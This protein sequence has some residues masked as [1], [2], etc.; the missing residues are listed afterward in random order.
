[1]VDLAIYSDNSQFGVKDLVESCIFLEQLKSVKIFLHMSM[2]NSI[3][4]TV[5][6]YSSGVI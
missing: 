4:K 1:M 5:Y 3:K 2:C 6:K